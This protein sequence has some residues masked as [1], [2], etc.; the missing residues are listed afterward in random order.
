MRRNGFRPTLPIPIPARLALTGAFGGL[1]ALLMF[2]GLNA[3]QTLNHVRRSNSENGRSYLLRNDRLEAVRA[4]AYAAAGHVRNYL[5]DP[6]ADSLNR[7]RGPAVSERDRLDAAIARYRDAATAE[8]IPLIA[9]LAVEWSD[10]WQ[11]AASSF[12]WTAE[13][14]RRD[15]Y[16]L[17][18][19]ELG[20]AR[21]RFLSTLDEIRRL[22]EAGLRDTIHQ[23]AAFLDSLERRLWITLCLTFLAGVSLTA[24]TWRHLARLEYEAASRYRESVDTAAQLEQL[25]R[26]LLDVQEQERRRIA[27]ELHDEVGQMLG[28]LLVDLGQAR[29]AFPPRAPEAESHL[30]SAID[31]GERTMKTVRDICLLLRPTMLDDL[32]LLPA[33]HW[34]ARETMRRTGLEVTLDCEEEDLELSDEVRTAVYRVIQEALQNA[35]RHSSAREVNVALARRGSHLKVIVKDDGAGFDPAVTRGLGLLGMQ[36]RILQIGG[37]F[38]LTSAPGQGTLLAIDVPL[39]TP[40]AAKE[41]VPA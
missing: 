7:H 10:Y 22:D 39:E 19:K 23:S 41:A 15:G 27:R 36:E 3:V 21:E 28:A 8:R 5:V 9:R 26:R 6:G 12:S 11:I 35:A 29:S 1:L 40:A 32:G 14:R 16:S 30:R 38:R 2:L 13:Q 4:A 34:Q 20:V 33:L 18:A 17:L 37:E 25:S 24:F 31:L